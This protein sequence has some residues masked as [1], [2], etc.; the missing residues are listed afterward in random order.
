[1]VDYIGDDGEPC[2]MVDTCL[3]VP[4]TAAATL[5]LLKRNFLRHYD[6]NRAPFGVFTHAA[7]FNGEDAPAINRKEG[8]RQF[9][10]YLLN[11]LDDVYLVSVAKALEWLRTPTK[12]ADLGSFEPW[13]HAAD[14]PNTCVRYN[15]HFPP[16]NVPIPGERYMASCQT[17]PRNYP[18][19]K[20]P[21]GLNPIL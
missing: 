9:L 12:T 6:G 19:L 17:C 11:E 16:E 21:Y 7:W 2:A 14:L 13:K 5:S 18:Y 20:N 4:L 1:M 3:P 8:Y 10:A 15:C